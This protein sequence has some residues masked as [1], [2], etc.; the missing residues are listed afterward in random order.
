MKLLTH[1]M[2][3]CHIKGVKDGYPFEIEATKI[4]ER[5]ADFDPGEVLPYTFAWNKSFQGCW[6]LFNQHRLLTISLLPRVPEAHLS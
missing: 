1:N 3:S 5:E 4:T 6:L 2:L